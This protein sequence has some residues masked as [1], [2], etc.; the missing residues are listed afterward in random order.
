MFCYE[1]DFATRIARLA[2]SKVALFRSGKSHSKAV[3]QAGP[4]WKNRSTGGA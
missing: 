2:L 1:I 4:G 3:I